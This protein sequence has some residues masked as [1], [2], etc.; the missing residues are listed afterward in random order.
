MTS[1][2]GQ[3]I[4]Y[5][6]VGPLEEMITVQVMTFFLGTLQGL[7]CELYLSFCFLWPKIGG[8]RAKEVLKKFKSYN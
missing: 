4:K 3:N 1:K 2:T 8:K 7:P 6:R 5:C